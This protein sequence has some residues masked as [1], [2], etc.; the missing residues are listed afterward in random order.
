MLDRQRS[1][2]TQLGATQAAVAA[3]TL[4][5]NMEVSLQRTQR[6]TKFGEA[7]PAQVFTR[8]RLLASLSS[9]CF[10]RIAHDL[11]PVRILSGQTLIYPDTEIAEAIFMEAGVASVLAFSGGRAIEVG[12]IGPEGMIGLPVVLN[13]GSSPSE[14]V[15]STDGDGLAISAARLRSAMES[16]AELRSLLMRYVYV[17]Q[18]QTADNLAACGTANIERRVARWLLTWDD[19]SDGNSL[20]VTHNFI[21]SMLGVRRAT[22]TD[23][24]HRLEG[25]HAIQSL[26]REV[27][28]RDREKLES[29]A[30]NIYGSAEREFDRLFPGNEMTAALEPLPLLLRHD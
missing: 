27:V 16:D 15:A 30:G 24:M 6:H 23:A 29:I 4:L 25:A 17:C 13:A 26:R 9:C 28:I 8:N 7:T 14:Y 18:M 1:L 19:R 2:V 5:Q 10:D 22:V 20:V 12:V 21:A 3:R 11:R